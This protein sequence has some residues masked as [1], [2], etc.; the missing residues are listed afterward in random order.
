MRDKTIESVVLTEQRKPKGI[1]TNRDILMQVTAEGKETLMTKVQ[2]II[3]LNPVV[4]SESIGVWD[5]F[6]QSRSMGNA[7]SL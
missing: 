7:V 3:T 6:R 2:D 4:V 1:L 5:L